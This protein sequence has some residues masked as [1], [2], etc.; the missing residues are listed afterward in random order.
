ME[1]R[2]ILQPVGSQKAQMHFAKTIQGAVD[3][4]RIKM[5]TSLE[6]GEQ[7][8]RIYPDG[9]VHL[10]GVKSGENK[11]NERMW[12]NISAGD[13]VLFFKEGGLFAY[14]TVTIKMK[15]RDLA[16]ALWKTDE[17]NEAWENIYYVNNIKYIDRPISYEVLNKAANYYSRYIV[18]GFS[19][20]GESKSKDILEYLRI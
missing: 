7:L 12:E 19:V 1:R 3:I 18:R 14:A 9:E 5:F 20:L 15:N 13:A 6:R 17:D 4:S 8:S 10:W 11:R 2:V 16:E